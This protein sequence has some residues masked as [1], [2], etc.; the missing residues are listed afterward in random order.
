MKRWLMTILLV[1][2]AF[3]QGDTGY[4]PG[5]FEHSPVFPD[6]AP[7]RPPRHSSPLPK[8]ERDGCHHYS[9]WRYPYPQSC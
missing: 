7:Q 6:S 1:T 5:L 3:A 9:D 4:P 2:P 8:H